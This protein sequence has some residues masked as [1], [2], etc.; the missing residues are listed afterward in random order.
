M[1]T[2]MIICLFNFHDFYMFFN[3][4]CLDLAHSSSGFGVGFLNSGFRLH[5]KVSGLEFKSTFQVL[6]FRF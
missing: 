2:M 3:M 6:C 4:G 5:V 1:L